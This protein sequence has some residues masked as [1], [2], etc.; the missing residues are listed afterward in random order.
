MKPQG[1]QYTNDELC[2]EGRTTPF[3]QWL[4]NYHRPTYF[5]DLKAIK[6]RV[7]E[8]KKA[9]P[10]VRAHYAMKANANPK[11]LKTFKEL[12]LHVDVVSGGEIK[13]ALASG[14]EP[15]D[16]IFSGVA[17]TKAELR[18][19]LELGIYQINVESLQELD[20]ISKIA[21][22]LGKKAPVSL[23]LNPDID[24]GTHPYIATGLRENKF[25]IDIAVLHEA[26]GVLHHHK[27]SLS[28]MGISFHLGSQMTDPSS[29]RKAFKDL[30]PVF[31]ELR[32]K[33]P[34]VKRLDFGGGLGIHY[35]ERLGNE[36]NILKS[37]ADIVKEE[38]AQFDAE[39]QCEPG[40]WLVAHAGVYVTQVQYVKKNAYKHFL[41]VDGGMNHLMRPCLYN[42]Y[43]EV[44][45]I[46]LHPGRPQIS[47]DVVGPICE[48]S[49]FLAKDRMIQEMKSDEFLA[50]ADAGAYGA[51]MASNYNMH[52]LPL[53]ICLE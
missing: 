13:H 39:L 6:N 10:P 2:F 1:L 18:Y 24:I 9:L 16:V 20:R 14:F 42:A 3:S 26:E 27:D 49:D 35:Q 53:E 5:Y 8:F 51:V 34:T 47:Y 19:A 33:F 31:D 50:V 11:I 43:H 30:K 46:K 4:G 29:M 38:A 25:G 17:K 7:A 21:K 40:R 44:Y 15:S 37:Y 52:E 12:G 32:S 45:P 36:E 28:L 22:Q 23:R 48:S 41:I